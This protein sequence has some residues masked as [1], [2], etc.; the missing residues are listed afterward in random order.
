MAQAKRSTT[1][2]KTSA[3]SRS[4][5][6]RSSSSMAPQKQRPKEEVE[7]GF[8]DYWHA[9]TKTKVFIPVMT[10]AVTAVLI[11]LDLLISWNDF[12]RFFM[13][14]GIELIAAAAVW[15]IATIFSL[16]SRRSSDSSDTK[17]A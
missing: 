14:L 11:G 4:S 3:P 2:K 1:K 8:G 10:V 17:E 12:H 15:L 6:G 7:V 16:G 5:A 9:F 13:F